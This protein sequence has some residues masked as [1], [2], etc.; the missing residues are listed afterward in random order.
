MEL[1]VLELGRSQDGTTW[2]AGHCEDE[3]RAG[4]VTRCW[5]Q[6]ARTLEEFGLVQWPRLGH[7]RVLVEGADHLVPQVRGIAELSREVPALP[8]LHFLDEGRLRRL[9]LDPDLDEDDHRSRVSRLA[10][11]LVCRGDPGRLNVTVAPPEEKHD[12]IR[13][14][15]A[16]ETRGLWAV[17]HR[18]EV[19]GAD[20]GVAERCGSR[21]CLGSQRFETRDQRAQEN[22]HGRNYP[23][24]V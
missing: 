23:F 22:L 24:P 7:E 9:R 10:V 18:A 13:L 17:G 5:N 11:L 3:L 14:A 20:H 12:G 19:L 15:Y 4:N 1:G 8:S 6:P 2:P 21:R 16:G